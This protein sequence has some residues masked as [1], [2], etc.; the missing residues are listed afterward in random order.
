VPQRVQPDRRRRLRALRRCLESTQRIARSHDSPNSVV[1]T[2]GL[3]CQIEPALSRSA[4]CLLRGS[5]KTSQRWGEWYSEADLAVW[6]AAPISRQLGEIVRYRGRAMGT[7]H[8]CLPVLNGLAR[9]S[10]PSI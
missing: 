5:R 1:S 2:Y 9:A 8:V 10:M 6:I 4:F 3:G 7:L